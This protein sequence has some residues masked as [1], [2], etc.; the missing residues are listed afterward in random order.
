MDHTIIIPVKS[1][2]EGKSRLSP[3][4]SSKERLALNQYLIKRTIFLAFKVA[5]KHRVVAITKC[6]DTLTYLENLGV[7]TLLET[8]PQGLNMALQEASSYVIEKGAVRLMILFTDLPLL[9]IEDLE[10]ILSTKAELILAPNQI[11][12]GTNCL[13]LQEK[14]PIT[15]Q[16]GEN[17]YNRHLLEAERLGLEAKTIRRKSLSFDLDTPSDYIFWKNAY[18][19]SPYFR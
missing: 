14:Y 13:V 2:Y 9:E 8:A 11:D 3:Y 19:D 17:S 6:L 4:L 7:H 1:L 10:E 12:E 15:Y 5:G 16:F 18:Q